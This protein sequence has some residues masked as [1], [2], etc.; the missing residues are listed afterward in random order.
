MSI[1]ASARAS[2]VKRTKEELR[3]LLKA[4]LDNGYDIL[5]TFHKSKCFGRKFNLANAYRFYLTVFTL[6]GRFYD[7][8]FTKELYTLI[9][10][11]FK[12]PKRLGIKYFPSCNYLQIDDLERII[13][14]CTRTLVIALEEP[15]WP[16]PYY[17]YIG[18][19]HIGFSNGEL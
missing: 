6:D 8:G 14:F 18:R 11:R 19:V 4:L 10:G 1:N 2:C 12:Q 7:Y 15:S 13:A 3:N 17:T 5:G 9:T 16:A